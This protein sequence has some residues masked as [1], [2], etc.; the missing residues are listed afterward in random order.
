MILDPINSITSI[1]FYKKIAKQ[2][3]GRSAAYLAYLGLIFAVVAT[4][5]LKVKVGPVVDETFLWLEK[6]MPAITF[7]DGKLSA[8]GGE[9]VTIRHPSIND[10]AITVD[11]GRTEPVTPELLERNKVI[12]YV[13]GNAMY[14][15][16][17]P[18][19]TRTFDFGKSAAAPGTKPV[20]VDAAFYRQAGTVMSRIL[21]PLS[22][23]LT[24]FIFLLWK[25]ISTGFYSLMSLLINAVTGAELEY[26]ALLNIT[27]YAQTLIITVQAIF[28]FMPV[29]LPAGGLISIAAT[30]AYVWLAVKRNM[31]PAAAAA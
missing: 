7:A 9:A 30:G 10:I 16:E 18:G 26:P 28:L 20:V 14:L 12:A 11:T 19:Q 21:Y 6:S 17:R 5:A 24:F 29:G 23:V 25:G 2:G 27:L 3:I 8:A 4:V 15:L 31:E 22:F 1:D 13:T